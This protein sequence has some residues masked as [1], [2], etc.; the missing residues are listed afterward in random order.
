MKKL[1]AIIL[2]STMIFTLAA[3]NSSSTTTQS[4]SSSSTTQTSDQTQ[5]SG[6]QI[7]ITFANGQAE[8]HAIN[9]SFQKFIDTIEEKSNGEMT[10]IIYPNGQLG[11]DS[12]VMESVKD[13]SIVMTWC[14]GASQVSLV[15]ELAIFDIPFLFS[16]IDTANRVINDAEFMSFLNQAY[17]KSGFKNAGFEATGYRW[18]TAN[19]SITTIDDLKGLKLRTM[20]NAYHIAFWKA[21]GTTPTPISNSELYAA[22]QQGTVDAQENSVENSYRRK[23]YEVQDTFIN[24]L[25]IIYTSSFPVNLEFYNSL[26]DEHKAIFDEAMEICLAESSA[27]VIENEV[28]ILKDLESMGINVIYSLEEGEHEKWANLAMPAAE[29]LIRK[30]LGDEPVDM[31][32]NA[33]G[34]YK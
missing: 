27:N 10:G 19:K 18:L 5:A 34:K 2:A 7:I 9:Q 28:E 33:V 3:C 21:L 20:E 15:P 13:G 8:D 25:H 4:Q 29:T 11:S 24:S 23:T 26:S 30:E 1:V 14:T 12:A 31:L 6:D 32:L 22:L 17:E 16:D